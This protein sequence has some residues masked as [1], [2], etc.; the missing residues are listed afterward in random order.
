MSEIKGVLNILDIK[1]I[2]NEGKKE[3]HLI[4]DGII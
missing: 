2:I 4:F 3:F 1:D